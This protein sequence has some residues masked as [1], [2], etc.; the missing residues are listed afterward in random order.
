[1]ESC[2]MNRT[3]IRST[4]RGPVALGVRLGTIV[5]I[6][7]ALGAAGLSTP[8]SATASP[9][10]R[11][12]GA[13]ISWKACDPPD[14][15]LECARVA[16]P[17]DWDKPNGQQIELAVIRHLASRPAERIG[18]MFVNPGGPGASGVGLVQGL[19][20]VLD[21]WG[22]GRFDVVS[23]DPRGTND[24]T[25]VDCF[26]SDAARD[27][28]WAGASIPIT[29]AESKAYQRKTVDLARR[30]GQ[31]NGDLLDHISTADTAR[32]LDALRGL[33]GDDRLTYVGLSYGSMIGQT[34]VNLFPKRIRAMV[35]DG[36]V[37]PVE[38]TKSAEARVTDQSSSFDAVFDTFLQMCESA[39]AG[40][41]ALAGHGETVAQRVARVFDTALR[42][43]IPAPH[44]DPPGALDYADLILAAYNPLRVRAD[45]AGFATDLNAAADGD[46]SAMED[47]AR[48]LRTPAGFAG[49]TTSSAISCV[50]GP[51]RKPAQSWP[52]VIPKFTDTSTMYGPL[53]GWWLW[54]PCAS[55]WPGRST[56]RY[57][58][59]WGAMTTT[60]ILLMNNR[61]D[62]ATGYQDAVAAEKRL[63]NAVLL[64]EDGY[65]H[66]TMND[67]SRCVDQVRTRYLVS[68]V[69]PARGTV[70][71][72]D[73][74]PF[75]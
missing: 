46:A 64:T 13:A 5:T 60:P 43:S 15:G 41:C 27:Q 74:S 35:L 8:S 17:L 54:A 66:L 59:P 72:A 75:G 26:T 47:V 56:D 37:D 31:V 55:N 1:M 24:S 57:A 14:S 42:S 18:S 2:S 62:P 69:P 53:L 48:A 32:D 58:G 67:P 10:P 19:S 71:K 9:G 16:V 21:T 7:V 4:R 68:L 3:L 36:I 34:Y 40:H 52:S 44:S 20:D 70:C 12:G 30:C 63:G 38:Y 25:P 6:V 50:D 22:D 61:N 33:V 51:A 23:W 11:G 73:V 65:G 39:G 28:F 49:A 45:W 29:K